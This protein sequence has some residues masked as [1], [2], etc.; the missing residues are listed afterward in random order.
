MKNPD[1]IGV[2]EV[3][4][5]DGP[6]AGGPAANESYERLIKNRRSW[7]PYVQIFKY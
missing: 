4:D 5:N 1:I 3:Q 6:N 2:T 7:R